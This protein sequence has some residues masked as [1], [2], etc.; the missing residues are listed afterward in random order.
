MDSRKRAAMK[1]TRIAI[2]RPRIHVI[3]G[4]AWYAL[5]IAQTPM[6]GAMSAM[7]SS[8]TSTICN[9]WT[10][11]VERVIS[12]AVENLWNSA[13][14]KLSTFAKTNSRTSREKPVAMRA[15]ER[16]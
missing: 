14:E 2:A 1:E 6:N 13:R 4:A 16:R 3:D 9:C 15:D 5:M 12:E 10:S 11:L 7:R 8:I